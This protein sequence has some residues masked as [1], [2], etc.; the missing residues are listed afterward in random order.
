MTADLGALDDD[1]L[2]IL[3]L[4]NG[5]RFWFKMVGPKIGFQKRAGESVT[6]E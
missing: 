1:T 3:T 6:L 4:R 2:D 5:S